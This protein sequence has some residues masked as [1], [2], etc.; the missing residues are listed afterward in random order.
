[1]LHHADAGVLN[2]ITAIKKEVQHL[3]RI[4]GPQREVY[5]GLR[6]VNL[7]DPTKAHPLLSRRLRRLVSDSRNGS[8]LHRLVDG[9]FAIVFEHVFQ[10]NG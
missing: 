1:M 3:R 10:P 8:I 4:I 5:G 7:A 6:E 9:C 2:K